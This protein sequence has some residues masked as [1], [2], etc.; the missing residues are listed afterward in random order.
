[1]QKLKKMSAI[2][3]AVILL[4]NLS[5]FF[6]E[7]F[8]AA[9]SSAPNVIEFMD[10]RI[11]A[12][13]RTSPYEQSMGNIAEVTF[14]MPG[15]T[16]KNVRFDK[17]SKHLEYD[18]VPDSPFI[19]TSGS[20]TT[21][22]YDMERRR[23]IDVS[24]YLQ[25]PGY[26]KTVRN[27]T[28]E[29]VEYPGSNSINKIS[30]DVSSPP[31]TDW[32]QE[33]NYEEIPSEI[34]IYMSVK[35]IQ[36][37]KG[38]PM[39]GW[40]NGVSFSVKKPLVVNN[41]PTLVVT[42]PSEQQ[43]GVNSLFIPII[44]VSDTNGDRLELKYFIDGESEPRETKFI[45]NTAT[46]QTV[47][48][49]PVN[50]STISEGN[51]TIRFIVSDG[52]V[53]TQGNIQIIVDKS[54]PS[55]GEVKVTSTDSQIQISGTA[56]DSI[57][58]LDSLPYRYSIGDRTSGWTANSTFNVSGLTSN[59][60][61]HTKFEAKDR[62]GNI[63][64][65][66]QKIYTQAQTPV[67]SVQQNGETSL[68]L[69]L[70]ENNSSQTPYLIKMGSYYVTSTGGVTSSP[71]WF[72]PVSKTIVLNGLIANTT[73]TFQ[74]KSKNNEGQETI[75]GASVNGTTLALAPEEVTAEPSQEWIKLAWPASPGALS[76]DIEVD[77]S[78]MNNGSSN[79]Y[80][81]TGLSPNTQ[82]I[83]K[84]RTNNA[85]G[86]SNWSQP[87]IK[88]TLPDPPSTPLQLLAVPTQNIITLSW[89]LVPK[90][91]R[92][93]VE[94]DGHIVDNGNK[95]SF[96]HQGL[97]PSTDHLYRVRASNSGGTSEWS[98]AIQQQTWPNPPDTPTKLSAV[99]S[100]HTVAVKWDEMKRA[101]GYEIEV[102][103]LI[104]DNKNMASYNHD[105]LDAL[106]GHTYR[107]RAKNIGGKSSWSAP[108]DVTTHP[109][110]PGIPTNIMTTSGETEVTAAWYAVP[111]ADSYD[112]EIDNK[113]V[114]N[115][116]D[117]SFVHDQL[118]ASSSHIY[119]IRAKN[120]SG[121]SDWSKPITMITMPEATNTSSL[122]N[123][124]AVVTNKGITLSWDT[125]A[126]DARYDIEVD[127][128]LLDNASDTIYNHTGLKAEE[129]HSYKI[130]VKQGNEIGDW[131]AVLSLSTLP[132]L[133]DAPSRLNAYAKD[134]SI[135][136]HWQKMNGAGGYQL[137][138]DGKTVDLE[139]G[140]SYIHNN[141]T[142]GT[143]HTYRVRAK[144]STGVTAWSPSLQKSTTS[145]DYHILVKKN[146]E[147]SLTLL[148][149]NVQD[150][151]E[152]HFVVTYDPN[153]LE[154]IDMYDFTPTEDLVNGKI[155]S[156][157]LSATY[158]PGKVTFAIDQNIVPGTSWSGE[159]TT[160][161]FKSKKT[162]ETS[163][164]VVVD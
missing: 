93:E 62:V 76:Y 30:F 34:E 89:D 17:I 9:A 24:T 67:L 21:W 74:A 60:N 112:V 12:F 56:S 57:S 155:A 137:E 146:E 69:L 163:V 121:N 109:E 16:L 140:T 105:G 72:T 5:G 115:V 142:S 162:G 61:Y 164:H 138:I 132:N 80:T 41:A 49:S 110:I 25:G 154:L 151:S 51:H 8:R 98:K 83:Y 20:R 14:T 86:T 148:A 65:K 87:L 78:T 6:T 141:L 139:N 143:A 97:E 70:I 103:G 117:N 3:M 7:D 157:N 135:E 156:S 104:M 107:V 114:V 2:F 122:T 66:E 15:V 113:T 95:N 111:H 158:T 28:W 48:F 38:Q 129:Y 39:N 101:S 55:L 4:F 81:H 153:E 52:K 100:I 37:E 77:G 118:T 73:Y 19:I 50:M 106:S 88:L 46:A 68:K 92:Y 149:Q 54:L 45:S 47:S 94:V 63:A 82:H 84:V 40:R 31:T 22:W 35:D 161:V 144:N 128:R 85:G 36:S 32:Y 147:C 59:T 26:G 10:I 124:V 58:G 11:D 159:I 150:F 160:L 134:T 125:V 64:V 130:R 152:L 91:S 44:Q 116:T 27:T 1:M 43:L 42:T 136:L 127:G 90:A 145:P 108:L 18:F 96:V 133:P 120:I 29:T 23:N 75:F 102:D 126:P 99:P 123:I 71:I 79:T 13:Q 33:W 131:V 119:R 53:S